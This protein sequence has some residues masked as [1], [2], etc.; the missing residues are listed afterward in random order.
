MAIAFGSTEDGLDL[1]G[2]GQ[3]NSSGFSVSCRM[4]V[5]SVNMNL[6]QIVQWYQSIGGNDPEY[7]ISFFNIANNQ[8]IWGFKDTSNNYP[9]VRWTTG[10]TAG[11]TH[12]AC[13]VWD[14]TD[15][16]IYADGDT[17]AKASATPAAG[18]DAGSGEGIYG[19]GYRNISGDRHFD[20]AISE[21]CYYNR[22]LT[23]AEAAAVT[24][25]PGFAPTFL[26]NAIG[27][28][29]PLVNRTYICPKGGVTVSE[30]ETPTA[31]AHPAVI[32]P[33]SSVSAAPFTA[34]A[35]SG[36]IMSSLA[37]MGGGLAGPGGLAGKH[38]GLAG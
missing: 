2:H 29:L 34:A 33:Q 24:A 35:A 12:A 20:G 10:W 32:Y 5:N 17:T 1:T 23:A 25:L 6:R 16:I 13:F 38:G 28:Y 30:T 18:I 14:G 8:L 7:F 21:F 9:D 31:A 27:F 11:S 22:A 19:I 26:L 3:P 36:R 4:L 37:G 15:L